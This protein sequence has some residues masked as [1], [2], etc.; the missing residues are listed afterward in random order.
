MNTDGEVLFT[1][2][3]P[4]PIEIPEYP[5]LSVFPLNVLFQSS[6]KCEE[7][8]LLGFALY[9]PDG[10]TYRDGPDE[11]VMDYKNRVDPRF[12]LEITYIK[13]DGSYRGVRYRGEEAVTWTTGKDWRRFFAHLGMVGLIDGELVSLENAG[14]A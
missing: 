11:A 2:F 4:R 10:N 13:A 1:S 3:I 14:N 5:E 12:H 6:K 8:V 9:L 7:G